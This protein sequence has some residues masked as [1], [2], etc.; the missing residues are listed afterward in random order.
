MSN[1]GQG[2]Q[3]GGY[4]MRPPALG[5]QKMGGM[6]PGG[7]G[8]REGPYPMPLGIQNAPQMPRPPV[9]GYGGPGPA[10]MTPDL[11]AWMEAFQRSRNQ[12]GGASMQQP[13]S[14]QPV[15]LLGNASSF[16]TPPPPGYLAPGAAGMFATRTR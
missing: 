14:P 11:M 9:P 7:G 13:P 5:A 3:G 16:G 12:G 1:S 8:F 15:G 2:M 4:P 6:Q 10:G